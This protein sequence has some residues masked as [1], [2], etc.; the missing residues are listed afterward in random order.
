VVEHGGNQWRDYLRFR[1]LLRHQPAMRSRYAELK[2]GLV[3]T[4][5]NDRGLYTA[6]EADFIRHAAERVS[7]QCT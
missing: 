6:S 1:D 4:C 7:S 3:S 2:R 5:A